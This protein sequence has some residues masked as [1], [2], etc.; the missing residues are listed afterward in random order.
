MD[1]IPKSCSSSIIIVFL[2]SLITVVIFSSCDGIQSVH[3]RASV[4]SG[5]NIPETVKVD[6]SS[7]ATAPNGNSDFTAVFSY[8]D[9][10]KSYFLKKASQ[11]HYQFIN[12]ADQLVVPDF[13][14]RYYSTGDSLFYLILQKSNATGEKRV[15]INATRCIIIVNDYE[16]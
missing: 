4:L 12:D 10:L 3:Q 11:Q 14:T 6:S 9:S 5:I 7:S 13:M 8:N 2:W 1:F 16:I 15:L